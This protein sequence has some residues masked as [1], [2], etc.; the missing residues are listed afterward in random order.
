ML[1]IP[2]FLIALDGNDI[3]IRVSNLEFL[4]DLYFRIIVTFEVNEHQ[5]RELFLCLC[6]DGS[7]AQLFGD[8]TYK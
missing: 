4:E 3:I 7:E 5:G 1:D 8:E 2:S 6:R